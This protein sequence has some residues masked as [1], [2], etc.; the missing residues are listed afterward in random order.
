MRETPEITV[1]VAWQNFSICNALMIVE[2]SV[3]EIKQSALNGACQKFQNEVVTNSESFLPVP[4]EIE[5]VVASAKCLGGEGF[6]DSELSDIAELL[7][8]HPQ[9]IV[10]KYFNCQ[11]REHITS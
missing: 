9:E 7:D 8:S 10:E 2:E 5:N 1:K 3:R 11:R 4:E 6:E